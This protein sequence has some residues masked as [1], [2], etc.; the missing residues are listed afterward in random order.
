MAG[1]EVPTTEVAQLRL[2]HGATLVGVRAAGV[3]PTA[4]RREHGR[5]R[6]AD[7]VLMRDR[8]IGIGDRDRVEQ[9]P[10]VGMG[11]PGVEV[12]TRGDLTDLAEVHDGDPIA[13]VLD[14]GEVVGDEDQRQSVTHLEVFEQVDDLGLD[15]DVEG[16]DRL[17]ADDQ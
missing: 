3:E 12:V 17:V 8:G 14:D 11:R 15:A 7:D 9:H 10:G 13:D 5:G 4:R 6:L 16:R 2:F 1:D